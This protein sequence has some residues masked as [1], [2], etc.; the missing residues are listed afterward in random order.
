MREP[1]IQNDPV[2]FFCEILNQQVVEDDGRTLGRVVDLTAD[3]REHEPPITGLIIAGLHKSRQFLQWTWVEDLR[4]GA[5]KVRPGARQALSTVERPPGEIFLRKGLLD[6]QIV[7]MAGAKVVR[8]NDLQLCKR[9]GTLVL[10]RVDVGL[11]GL[12]RRVG[13]QRLIAAA[14]KWLFAY[15]LADTLINWR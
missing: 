12:L 11:R 5:V 13:I 9:N 1:L 14:L 6:K 15:S 2:W 4:P 3:V 10:S 8:V 7:D